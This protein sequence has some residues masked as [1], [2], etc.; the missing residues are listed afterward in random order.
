MSQENAGAHKSKKGGD[1]FQH[2]THPA[3]QRL[4]ANAN[5]VA[6]SKGFWRRGGLPVVLMISGNTAAGSH[7]LYILSPGI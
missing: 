3:T 2:L 1:C 4:S 7:S 5:R 6:Q